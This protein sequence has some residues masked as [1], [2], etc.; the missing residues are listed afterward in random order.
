MN[1]NK[2][3]GVIFISLASLIGAA[4]ASLIT[5]SDRAN[6]NLQGTIIFNSNFNDFGA[7][8]GFP[9]NPFT[10]GDVTYNS[11]DNLTWGSQ[12]GYTTTETLIGNNWWTP[13]IGTIA[14]NPEY[15]MFGFD[16]GTYNSSSISFNIFTNLSSYSFPNLTIANS[17]IG[18][19]E[20]RGF[21]AIE[22]EYF[23]GFQIIADGGP[24]NLPG[25]TNVTL[26]SAAN[27]VPEGGPSM[28]LLGIAIT[29]LMCT[30]SKLKRK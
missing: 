27:A 10:R 30:K 17:A 9:G 14:A 8:F 20:F 25:L 12:T 19:L 29:G 15:R 28:S 21:V 11:S 26:G 1:I 24:G 3:A 5:Y 4:S 16:I 6:F 23:T 22:G 2:L 13:I 7:N 18:N